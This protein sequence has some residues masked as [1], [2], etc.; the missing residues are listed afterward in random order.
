MAT[1][2]I[3]AFGECLVWCD[4]I[5]KSLAGAQ[6]S[7]NTDAGT[8]AAMLGTLLTW[9]S[10]TRAP[11]FLMATANQLS[12]LPAE[13]LRAGRLDSIFFVDLPTTDERF[14]IIQI[15]NKKYGSSLPVTSNVLAS[16]QG[17]TG[18]EIE[19]WAKDSLFDGVEEAH[20]AIVPLSKT[21]K[22]DISAIRDWA[23]TRARIANSPEPEATELR[24]IR[25]A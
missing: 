10:E 2:V 23:K 14:E 21:M 25:T 24:R 1:Q 6:S 15:M 20:K 8:T 12:Q 22:E 5:E 19:Q 18:A 11:I 17:W 3:E 16:T 4:E 13:F 7:G 9:M